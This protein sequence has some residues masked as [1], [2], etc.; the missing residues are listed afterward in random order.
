MTSATTTVNFNS[1]SF[2]LT[3]DVPA[4]LTIKMDLNSKAQVTTAST[5]SVYAGIGN[6]SADGTYETNGDGNYDITARGLSSGT[7]I[8]KATITSDGADTG[9][10]YVSNAYT[11]HKGILTV[12]KNANSPSGTQTAG[13]GKEVLRFDLTAT[14]DDILISELEFCMSGS[15]DA[16]TGTG[17][18]TLKSSDEAT[19]YG[20]I[21][22]ALYEDYW[23]DF[24]GAANNATTWYPMDVVATGQN[25]FSFG[26]ETATNVAIF[27]DDE[28]STGQGTKE[29]TTPIS[30]TAGETK[31][32]KLFGDTTGAATNKTLQV[33]IGPNPTSAKAITT[34]GV[35]YVDS[36]T[37][38]AGTTVD[39]TTTKNL[40]V[41]GGSLVY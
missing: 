32:L 17:D 4:Y 37:D 38:A 3:K 9:A 22:Q 40:P 10:I 28:D 12:S 30:V 24:G 21:T 39:L 33:T 41:V 6:D 13:G 11:F 23:Q 5:T 36:S 34:S 2:V 15:A 25:C 26:T 29:F 18:V 16:V 31:T 8:T 14:G 35:R 1:G 27:T 20:T 7:A 19:T